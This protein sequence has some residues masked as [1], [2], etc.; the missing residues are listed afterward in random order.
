MDKFIVNTKSQ[1]TSLK[2][3][4]PENY[5]KECI[6]E[7]YRLGD[8]MNKKTKV[9]AIMTTYKI[10]NE[11]KIFDTLL[12]NIL[13]IATK[14]KIE[15]DRGIYDNK[16]TY[17][18]NQSLILKD[19]WGAI[20]EKGHFTESHD[21][22]SASSYLSFVY[23]LQAEPNTPLIL[24]DDNQKILPENDLFAIFPSYV[25]H[26]VPTHEG[27]EDRIVLA[28]NINLLTEKENLNN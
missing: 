11:S 2:L 3:G 12:R 7:I 28:G 9:Q 22:I 8:S 1:A 17:L 13:K 24:S 21:H 4:I 10:F 19:T 27:P 26:K 14:I 18:N 20:Y 23:Y 16:G 5:R 25:R 15:E 6:K